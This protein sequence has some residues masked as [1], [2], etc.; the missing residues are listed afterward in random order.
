MERLH[1]LE[2]LVKELSGQ[3][4]QVKAA[5]DGSS[6]VNSP[7]SSTHEKDAGHHTGTSGTSGTNT[8]TMQKHFGRMVVQ[9]ANQSR[10]VS[11]GFWS[12]V[13]DEVCTCPPFQHAFSKVTNVSQLDALKM[14]TQ[15]LETG[16]SDTSDDENE[17]SAGKTPD[18]STHELER[19]PSERH[20]FLF[21][22][23]LDHPG[24]GLDDFRPLPS[25]IP[26]LLDTFS[27]NVNR[28]MQ[29]VHTP[30][31]TKMIRGSRGKDT[32]LTPANEALMFS[33]YYAAVISME[34]EDVSQNENHSLT[35]P[36]YATYSFC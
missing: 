11:S 27:E 1:S 4:G 8:T 24:P 14:S 19:A 5:A 31:I 16:D 9:D 2:C 15:G 28:F 26:F 6:G 3:L 21:R 7:G 36:E 22:H 32:G 35:K 25:Q 10:Y 17:S 23:N 30:S 33:I 29:L 18:T 20:A 12:R 34:Q 13:S